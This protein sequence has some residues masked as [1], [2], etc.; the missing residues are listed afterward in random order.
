[1]NEKNKGKK[2][3]RKQRMRKNEEFTEKNLINFR[4]QRDSQAFDNVLVQKC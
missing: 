4:L 2:N 3:E 1:M